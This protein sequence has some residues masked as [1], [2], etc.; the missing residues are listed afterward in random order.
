MLNTS[1][2]AV[3]LLSSASEA[4]LTDGLPPMLAPSQSLPQASASIPAALQVTLFEPG[5][6]VHAVLD[7]TR[8]GA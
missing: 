1:V 7:R 6:G 2:G 3:Q 8:V 4:A 5:Q